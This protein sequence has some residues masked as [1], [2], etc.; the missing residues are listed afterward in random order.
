MT[1]LCPFFVFLSSAKK[2]SCYTTNP[3]VNIFVIVIRVS[4][5]ATATASGR[6]TLSCLEFVLKVSM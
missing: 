2:K 1:I 6:K 5:A 3:S 4:N